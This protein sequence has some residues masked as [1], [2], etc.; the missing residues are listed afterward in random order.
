[1]EKTLSE[2][3]QI[4]SG[5]IVGEASKIIRN[6]AGFEASG[7]D[8][9]TYAGN[10]LY[11]KQVDSA[12]A[13]AVLVPN[14]FTGG[15]GKNL[16]LVENPRIAFSNLSLIFAPPKNPV[17][18]LP[19]E[20]HI[21]KNFSCGK[22]VSIG[23]FVTIGDDV[24]LGDRVVIHGNAFIGHQVE[25]KDD[26][27]IYPQVTILN[28][29]K[30]G[31]RVI[32]HAGSIIGSDGF[33]FE[34]SGDGFQKIHHTGIVQ[35]DDDVRIGAANTI[36]RGTT[37]KTWI[38]KGVKTDNLVHIG[39]NV[40]VG[41]NTRLVAQVGV[42]GSVTIGKHVVLAGKVG[43]AGHLTIGDNVMAGAKAGIAKSIPEGEVVSGYPTMPH[44]AWL[45]MVNVLPTLP[46]LKRRIARLEK[47]INSLIESRAGDDGSS[48]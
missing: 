32:V 8:D 19:S 27:E 11:L 28:G 10:A 30:I 46:E 33:G 13:G 36:D 41:E 48:T 37:G 12:Q 18:G 4:V 34:A 20:I 21:G 31:N 44:A 16:I 6:T 43:V 35:I 3:A 38:Q 45:R 9:I 25:L 22:D 5:R 23:P 2:I 24:V 39:H 29:A 17:C 14:G 15:K 42:S 40:V 1:M 26:V 47:T 7:I